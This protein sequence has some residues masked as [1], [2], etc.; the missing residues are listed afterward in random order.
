MGAEQDM[1]GVDHK[2][3]WEGHK[4]IIHLDMDAFFAAIEQLINPELRGRPVIVGGTP[5]SRGVVSTC[6]YEARNYGVHSAMPMKRAYELCPNAVFID[7]SG[8]KYS[9]MS[10]EVVKILR[11]FSPYVES[12][13]IDEAFMNITAIWRRYGSPRKAAGA[14]KA[15][16]K[17]KLG[18]TASVGVAPNR[19]VA[20][21]ASS[22]NKP[23]GLVVIQPREVQQFLWVQPVEHLWGV[24]PKSTEAMNKQGIKTIGDLAKAP[25]GK[26]K[27]MFGILGPGLVRMAKGDGADDVRE[28][29]IDYDAKSMGH[30]HTFHRDT[31]D[32]DRVTGLLLYLCDKV[33]RRLRVSHSE[34]RTVTLKVRISNFKLLTRAMSL[35]NYIDD[36]K[37]IYTIAK[38]LLMKNRF[39]D[40]PIRLIGVSV[41]NLREKESVLYDDL[42]EKCKSQNQRIELDKLLDNLRDIHGEDSVF[43]AGTQL[44]RFDYP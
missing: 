11:E 21:M 26:L 36:E 22:S 44:N 10:V 1:G 32:F 41:S 18:L 20:K 13:S 24:G 19:F 15:K 3:I 27:K 35:K 7:V 9:Y 42:L 14:I 33:S 23:D 6:S 16:I 39:L 31:K 40:N 8:G 37:A 29:H 25:E 4:V 43:F 2:A 12:V 28:S 30:E 38:K 5:D 34:A 17:E